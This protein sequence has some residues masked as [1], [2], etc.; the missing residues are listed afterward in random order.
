MMKQL[1]VVLLIGVF[2]FGCFGIG[3]SPKN[4]TQQGNLSVD[5]STNQ[6]SVIIGKQKNQTVVGVGG[7][8]NNLTGPENTAKIEFENAPEKPLGIYFIDVGGAI[9]HGNAILI[10]KGGFTMLVDAGPVENSGRVVDFLKGKGV[11][12]VDVLVSTNAD[13]RNYGGITKIADNFAIQSFWW[14]GNDFNDK[15]YAQVISR[16]KGIA[17]EVKVVEEGNGITIDGIQFQVLNPPKKR[18]N[19]I[20][21]DAVVIKVTNGQFSTLLTSGIQIGAQGKI[22]NEQADAIRSK[23]MLAPYYGTGAGT[24]AISIFLLAVKPEAVIITGSA[25]DSVE[26]GASRAP[27]KRIMTQYNISWYET[28]VNGTFRIFNDGTNIYSI[29]NVSS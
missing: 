10:K 9:T 12:T 11:N 23:V 24:N 7:K 3:E 26:N 2:L 18:F 8:E 5:N 17:K 25:D 28:Y 19:D 22:A 14:G 21:N 6:I 13:P 4:T 20:N 15:N 27:F 1:L 16:V 29:Q